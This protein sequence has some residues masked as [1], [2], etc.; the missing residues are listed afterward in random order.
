MEN[1]FLETGAMLLAFILHGQALFRQL[2]NACSIHEPLMRT[3]S[4]GSKG[5]L[6][7]SDAEVQSCFQS[8]PQAFV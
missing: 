8:T 4:T 7:P 1:G 6:V 3:F 5:D 2:Q